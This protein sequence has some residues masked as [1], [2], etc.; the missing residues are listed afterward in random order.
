M[1]VCVPSVLRN[2]ILG[3]LAV[4]GL[5]KEKPLSSFFVFFLSQTPGLTLIG[6]S[7][8]LY[9]VNEG[10][11]KVIDDKLNEILFFRTSRIIW[12]RCRCS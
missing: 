7:P 11:M 3:I 9:Y 8:G 2:Y 1:H 4:C 12:K 10:K 5:K 6:A